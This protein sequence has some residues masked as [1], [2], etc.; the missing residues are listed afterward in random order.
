MLLPSFEGQ[1]FFILG[2]FFLVRLLILFQF[3]LQI[4][5]QSKGQ[6]FHSV[7][8]QA[9][10]D[11]GSWMELPLEVNGLP[12]Y[13]NDT[14]GLEFVSFRILHS[15]V[16]DVE[17]HLISPAGKD[18]LL[19]AGVGGDGDD[20]DS[21][22]LGGFGYPSIVSAS[23]PFD[24]TFRSIQS[25]GQMNNGQIGNGTW[26]LKIKDNFPQDQG[27]IINWHL[28]FSN[29]PAGSFLFSSSNLPI[30][31]LDTKGQTIVDEPKIPGQ[32]RLIFQGQGQ[33]NYLA[34][35][36]LFPILTMGIELRGSSSQSFPKKSYG[37]EFRDNAGNDTAISLLGMPKES[38][39]ILS[40][41]YSDKTFMRNAFA[42]FMA[43]KMGWYAPR[44]RY[45]ELV[46][47]G[48]YQ[49]IFVLTE[50]IKRDAQRVNISSLKISDTTGTNVTGGYIF[51]IDKSTGNDVDFFTSQYPPTAQNQGQTIR[52]F[53]D[54]PKFEDI[55]PRQKEYLKAYVDSFENAL[56]SPGYQHPTNGYRR[57]MNTS[58]FVDYFLINE[59]SKNT[60]GYRISTFLTKPKITQNGGKLIAGPVWDYDLAWR[61]ADYC[62]GQNTTGWEIDFPTV[63]P[64]DYFQPPFWWRRLRQDPAFNQE[65]KCRWE[66][67]TNIIMPP[68][69]RNAW[70][71]SVAGLLEEAQQ[72][73]FLYWP[74]LGQY[75]WPNPSPI[76]T[77]Y[78]GEV[79]ALKNWL[80]NRRSWIQANIGST[81]L[82]ENQQ[83]IKV[84]GLEGIIIP[85]PNDGKFRISGISSDNGVFFNALGKKIPI[86]IYGNNEM[87]ISHLPEGCYW[88]RPE[89]LSIRPLKII[90]R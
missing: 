33:R 66:E 40:A 28:S 7:V 53:Y 5:T 76:P 13:L 15:Y 24:G 72:R 73:N 51:K 88:F 12:L 39:W 42:Y 84:E 52:F 61:N 64:D 56:A 69:V 23:P 21:T 34:D 71:D 47:N 2:K 79:A 27:F 38:D 11:D 31:T 4:A 20:M 70:I 17:M 60:D 49:G 90:K 14:F 80:N 57:F 6:S 78:S 26:R 85:N 59:W 30:I 50:K 75:V 54:Y 36:A 37:F 8:N 18:I 44:T 41:N 83:E 25:L 62:G 1:V 68:S 67:L 43:S 65:V 58:S 86:K 9:I 10:P 32:F 22:V 77:T 81:C 19:V 48:E 55:H 16:S 82:V 87:D 46:L 29:N 63:C 35:S 3:C 89:N 74:I 45:V